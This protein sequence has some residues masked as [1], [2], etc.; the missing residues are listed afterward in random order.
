MVIF[1]SLRE[2]RGLIF[3]MSMTWRSGW[4]RTGRKTMEGSGL[5]ITKAKRMTWKG[6][7]FLTVLQIKM[8]RRLSVLLMGIL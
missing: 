4:H 8:R 7:R 3:P 1:M 2:I 6:I 5:V